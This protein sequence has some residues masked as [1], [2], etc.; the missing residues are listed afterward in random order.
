[1]M[2]ARAVLG[3]CRRESGIAAGIPLKKSR[4]ECG[5]GYQLVSNGLRTRALCDVLL[6]SGVELAVHGFELGLVDV[7]VDFGRGHI[8]MTEQ[9]LDDA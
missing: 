6:G 5:N 8:G 7:R 9:F 2:P 3:H 1:M 4:A